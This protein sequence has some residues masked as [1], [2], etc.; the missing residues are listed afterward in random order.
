[1]RSLNHRIRC[2]EVF[3]SMLVDR[4]AIFV[5]QSHT[6]IRTKIRRRLYLDIQ[7]AINLADN[8]HRMANREM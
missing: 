8:L 3:K 4:A 6:D 7:I 1:M 5:R 2:I